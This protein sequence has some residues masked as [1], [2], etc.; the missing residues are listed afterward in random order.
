MMV[1]L[2]TGLIRAYRRF[3]GT[4]LPPSCR[5]APTCSHYAEGALA[6]HG[7]LRGA[8]LTVWRLARCNPFGEYGYDPV[9][10]AGRARLALKRR[11]IARSHRALEPPPSA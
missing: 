5:F 11:I 3:I 8:L 6:T 10:P 9:P 1:R 7:A 2:G 4:Y